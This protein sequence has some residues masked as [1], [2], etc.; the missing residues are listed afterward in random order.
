MNQSK[1][2]PAVLIVAGIFLLFAIVAYLVGDAES[3]NERHAAILRETNIL[4]VQNE[5][6]IA[7]RAALHE[8]TTRF[9]ASRTEL[10]RQKKVTVELLRRLDELTTE[11]AAQRGRLANFDRT[12]K[13][14]A[15]HK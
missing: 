15:E 5:Q 8:Q 11:V 6:S 13:D 14:Q 7:D 3:N 2:G 4:R 10:C 9:A 1:R 12:R